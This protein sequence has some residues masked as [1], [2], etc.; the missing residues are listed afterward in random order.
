MEQ[1]PDITLIQCDN[2]SKSIRAENIFGSIVYC[3]SCHSYMVLSNVSERLMPIHYKI[4]RFERQAQKYIKLIYDYFCEHGDAKLFNRLKIENGREIKRYYVPIREINGRYIPLIDYHPILGKI[5]PQLKNTLGQY[6][7]ALKL[8]TRADLIPYDFRTTY[9]QYECDKIEILPIE[10]D[11]E[12]IDALYSTSW[13][14]GL[15]VLY[16]PIFVYMT[17]L[18]NVYCIGANNRFKIINKHEVDVWINIPKKTTFI[19][20]LLEN[21][22]EILFKTV[23]YIIIACLIYGI[24]KFFTI[25]MTFAL[26]FTIVEYVIMGS[27]MLIWFIFLAYVFVKSS[28]I[29]ASPLILFY[30]KYKEVVSKHY[31]IDSSKPDYR[32]GRKVMNLTDY[33]DE[34]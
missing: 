1:L 6:K 4:I 33:H 15:S 29:I 22:W 17:N 32:K 20:K 21:K 18:G 34:Q 8:Q 24:Y 30:R 26:F 31:K 23:I 2:C 14:Q 25:G 16:V 13:N 5:L 9:V 27:L 11:L 19:D 28:I 7:D 3:D 10:V 12:K